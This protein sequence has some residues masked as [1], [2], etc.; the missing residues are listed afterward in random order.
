[1]LDSI[2]ALRVCE[3]VAQSGFGFSVTNDI[4]ETG[5]LLIYASASLTD[6]N[7]RAEVYYA[8]CSLADQPNGAVIATRWS[9]SSVGTFV[10]QV[11]I[12][13]DAINSARVRH[14]GTLLNTLA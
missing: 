4:A 3:I 7:E 9:P 12:T 6:L 1:M 10:M 5:C 14:N 8:I 11:P 2:I 13:T